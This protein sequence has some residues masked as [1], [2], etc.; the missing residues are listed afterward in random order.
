MIFYPIKYNLT[1]HTIGNILLSNSSII[2]KNDMNIP[3]DQT[4]FPSLIING[5]L[6]T[7]VENNDI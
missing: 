1:Y 6:A 2:L 4:T 7:L 5:M 3:V